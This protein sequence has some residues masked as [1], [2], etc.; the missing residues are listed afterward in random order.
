MGL[1]KKLDGIAKG[2]ELVRLL[3]FIVFFP[4]LAPYLLIEWII[5]SAKVKEKMK[6]LITDKGFIRTIFI[7][8]G[9]I[10]RKFLD[11]K[12]PSTSPSRTIC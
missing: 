5:E 11:I 2:N 8:F 10:V 7:Q 6:D 9:N 4:V 3:L 1:K 12:Y